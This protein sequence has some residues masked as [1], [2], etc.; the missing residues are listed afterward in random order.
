MNVIMVLDANLVTKGGTPIDNISGTY[1][2]APPIPIHE[3]KTPIPN[4]IIVNFNSFCD[5]FI[6]SLLEPVRVGSFFVSDLCNEKL[7]KK[8]TNKPNTNVNPT[9]I[10]YS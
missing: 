6:A 7:V 4:P 9:N 1:T 3:A 8:V 2:I 10:Q 5:E